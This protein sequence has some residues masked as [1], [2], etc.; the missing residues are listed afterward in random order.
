[1]K[2]MRFGEALEIDQCESCGLTWFDQ[3]EHEAMPQRNA[4]EI[5]RDA[6]SKLDI[7]VEP[8]LQFREGLS[9][10]ENVK[11]DQSKFPVITLLL[12][13]A[14]TV[15][16]YLA[17]GRGYHGFVYHAGRPFA[18]LGIPALLSNF[19]HISPAHLIGNMI[20]FFLP[21]S[22]VESTLGEKVLLKVFFYSACASLVAEAV[23][24]PGSRSLGASAAISGIFTVLC[25][26]QPKAVHITQDRGFLFRARS[27]YTITY[28]V[29][30]WMMY[31]LWLLTQIM[32]HWEILPGGRAGVSYLS[33]LAGAV[34][35]AAFVFCS[36]L[37][38]L[39][40]GRSRG[41]RDL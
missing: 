36:D 13:L 32:G 28:T 21:G 5:E 22:L 16:T 6:A 1:M 17:R 35:G 39:T 9:P 33:H 34:T 10:Y 4:A 25:L 23:L 11:G 3:G 31:G 7:E 12:V 14:C 29:P 2:L 24:A 8:S 27:F 37:K 18:G 30:V 38:V 26:T 41:D 19:A 20:F 40:P 15:V